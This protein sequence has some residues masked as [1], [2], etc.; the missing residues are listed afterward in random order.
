MFN[1]T[2]STYSPFVFNKQYQAPT[3]N[4][5]F[6]FVVSNSVNAPATAMAS[7]TN[8]DNDMI[9]NTAMNAGGRKRRKRMVSAIL[10]NPTITE[11]PD[12]IYPSRVISNSS[13][14]DVKYDKNKHRLIE[15]GRSFLFG[16]IPLV[17]LSILNTLVFL[18]L[19]G[20]ILY[21]EI[22]VNKPKF[23]DIPSF[24]LLPNVTSTNMTSNTI[25]S[26][27]TVVTQNI[28]E[29]TDVIK[30]VCNNNGVIIQSALPSNVCINAGRALVNYL[31][32]EKL[33]R[34]L[35]DILTYHKTKQK[36][37]ETV[38]ERP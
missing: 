7:N 8:S 10:E 5:T 9:T 1:Q 31:I 15:S 17:A 14:S 13:S 29:D 16:L 18:G 11:L 33:L 34:T 19:S 32:P 23:L 21:S 24:S 20:Y 36:F 37:L 4:Y 28:N 3:S 6:N 35:I 30:N 26:M 2:N 22:S 12:S 38:I 25:D 27:E